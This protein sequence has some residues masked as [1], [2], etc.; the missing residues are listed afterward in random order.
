MPRQIPLRR[1]RGGGE[2]LDGCI[3][4]YLKGI[5]GFAALVLLL[6]MCGGVA[7]IIRALAPLAIILVAGLV[8]FA[9]GKKYQSQISAWLEVTEASIE[10][11]TSG[12]FAI[13]VALLCIIGLCLLL[14]IF[15]VAT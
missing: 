10:R 1:A 8:I 11:W 3:N 12:Q 9:I 15:A 6:S 5:V 14:G 7:D 2:D 4:L 13:V